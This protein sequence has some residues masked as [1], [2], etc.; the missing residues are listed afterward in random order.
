MLTAKSTMVEMFDAYDKANPEIYLAFIGFTGDLVAAGATRGGAK[1]ICERIRWETAVRANR[2]VGV[3]V[4]KLNNNF[5][6]YYA[7]KAA[8]EFPAL[9]GE[10][11]Q[12]RE[13]GQ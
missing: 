9:F 7:R 3:P 4:W 2:E 6:A 12:M 13:R 10:F 5:T 11:F 1:M 8:A